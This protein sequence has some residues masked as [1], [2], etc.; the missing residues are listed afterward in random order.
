M[1]LACSVKGGTWLLSGKKEAVIIKGREMAPG[2]IKCL[3][4][5]ATFNRP[6]AY[7]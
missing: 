4:V 7:N 2:D 1:K 6:P 5:V 3:G